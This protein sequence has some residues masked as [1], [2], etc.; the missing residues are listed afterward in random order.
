MLR[1]PQVN[2]TE[3]AI[4]LLAGSGSC[5]SQPLHVPAAMQPQA[6]GP[7]RSMQ[8]AAQPQHLQQLQAGAGPPCVHQV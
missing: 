3:E 2:D 7:L 8:G 5:S 1:G 4:N 6:T